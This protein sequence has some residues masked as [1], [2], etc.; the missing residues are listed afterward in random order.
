MKGAKPR[1]KIQKHEI[2]KGRGGKEEWE[3]GPMP[4]KM[5]RGSIF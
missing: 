5:V 4:G 2:E 1:R 3:A